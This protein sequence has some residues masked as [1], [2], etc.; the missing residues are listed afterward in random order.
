MP[1][2]TTFEL[3]YSQISYQLVSFLSSHVDKLEKIT[4][5]NCIAPAKQVWVGLINLFLNRQPKQLVD[6]TTTAH[7][8][9]LRNTNPDTVTTADPSRQGM[10]TKVKLRKFV[11]GTTGHDIRPVEEN[12]RDDD[13]ELDE[14]DVCALW[15]QLEALLE[16]NRLQ[17]QGY[18]PKDVAALR[19]A[20]D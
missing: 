4:L 3:E 9:P 5:R 16:R 6:F 18:S 1:H 10:S 20:T 7:Y 8:V 12:A 14:S 2:I 17:A 13:P 15:N 11:V 19:E